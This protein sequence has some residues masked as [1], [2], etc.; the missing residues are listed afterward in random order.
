MSQN[1]RRL[2]INSGW[3]NPGPPIRLINEPTES[4]Y[5][6]SQ[7]DD[8]GY[9]RRKDYL[10]RPGTRMSIRARFALVDNMQVGTAGFGFWNAPFGDPTIGWPTLPKSAWFFYASEPNNLP[11]PLNSPGRG[12]FAS[13]LDATDRSSLAF[14]PL[15]PLFVTLNN[16]DAIRKILWPFIRRNLKISFRQIRPDREEW[17]SYQIDWLK[18]ICVFRIDQ[19]IVFETA[20]SPVGPMGFVTWIDNQYLI[21]TP[22]GRVGWGTIPI[23]Q[24]QSLEIDHVSISSFDSQ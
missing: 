1:F 10:W 20:S 24:T 11:L 8:Y 16:I 17:H 7:L 14:I 12:W 23:H 4:G 3:I 21:A 18:S 6:N 2:E 9:L 15:A 19:K 22:T 13:T 5:T